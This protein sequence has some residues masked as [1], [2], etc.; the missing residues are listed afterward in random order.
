M[1]VWLV[2]APPWP[3]F[4]EF[5]DVPRSCWKS[6]SIFLEISCVS[7][8]VSWR[9]RALSSFLSAGGSLSISRTAVSVACSMRW[10]LVS[11][12]SSELILFFCCCSRNRCQG[13]TNTASMMF[14]RGS[15]LF[16]GGG[17]KTA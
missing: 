2:E 7:A 14:L 8:F 16:G 5:F 1:F 15:R 6:K 12:W 3:L 13:V 9:I 11:L 17:G 10:E 4:G